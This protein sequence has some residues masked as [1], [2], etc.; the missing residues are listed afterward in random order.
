M[1]E[2]ITVCLGNICRS[3]IAESVLRH[4]LSKA[5]LEAHVTVRSAGTGGWHVGDDA[6]PR[7]RR[8][9]RDNGYALAHSA[10]QFNAAWFEQA[11]LVVAM[12]H[13][14]YVDLDR[15]RRKPSPARLAMFRSFDPVLTSLDPG[16]PQL[17]VPDPYYGGDDGFVDVLRMIERASQGLVR[18]L[19]DERRVRV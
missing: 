16:D 1:Y 4:H 19:Q 10:Q 2:I 3:P 6:D 11:D 7:A 17:D 9:L 18:Q 12:D 8:V 13:R 15:L 14:N 5:G